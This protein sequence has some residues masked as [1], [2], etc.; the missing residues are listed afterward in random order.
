VVS[1]AVQ[2]RLEG[3]E[4]KLLRM[5]QQVQ[6]QLTRTLEALAGGDLAL[7]EEVIAR[8]DDLDHAYVEVEQEILRTLA[9]HAPIARDLRVVAAILHVNTHLERMGDLCVNVAKFT[10][11]MVDHRPIPEIMATIAEMGTHAQ[12]LIAAAMTCFA[13]RDAALAES[14]PQL[15]APLDRLNQQI[16]KQIERAAED[17]HAVEWAS[18]MVLVARFLERLGDHSVDIGEQVSFIVTGEVREFL[19]P[20]AKRGPSRRA[21]GA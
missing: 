1:R 17:Q 5:G 20:K 8:D 7:A 14:L 18:R 9:L 10:R 11:F 6:D 13:R 21:E 3:L 4:A 2:A 15:D 16:F 12:T 19:P